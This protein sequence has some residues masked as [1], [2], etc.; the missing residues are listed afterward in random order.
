MRA[1]TPQ[2]CDLG[3]VGWKPA[4]KAGGLTPS[5]IL[6]PPWWAGR[7]AVSSSD[8]RGACDVTKRGSAAPTRAPGAPAPALTGEDR[9]APAP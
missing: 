4:S 6:S 7:P 8:L 1:D 2:W 5:C 9:A 3:C